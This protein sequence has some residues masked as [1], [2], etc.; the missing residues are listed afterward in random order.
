MSTLIDGDARRLLE[1]SG[2]LA[3]RARHSRLDGA[4]GN[5]A[6]GGSVLI[7]QPLRTDEDEGFAQQR[8]QGEQLPVEIG[9]F[10]LRDLR[11][12]PCFFGELCTGQRARL[13]FAPTVLF[14][15]GVA[16]NSE[17]PGA[18]VRARREL[19]QSRQRA[20]HRVVHEIVRV[21]GLANQKTREAAQFR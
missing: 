8:A 2:Q 17:H 21:R 13:G 4:G 19:M 9:E 3:A 6:D 18:H 10:E 12:R 15:E 16:E 14:I 1:G 7:A 5:S 11:G 20:C